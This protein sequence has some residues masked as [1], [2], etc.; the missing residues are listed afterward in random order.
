[1]MGGFYSVR[2]SH[3]LGKAAGCADWLVEAALE[4]TAN[5]GP[6]NLKGRKEI[7]NF[8]K[9]G[10]ERPKKWMRDEMIEQLGN[11]LLSRI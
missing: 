4:M 9:T 5:L 11:E 7:R 10:D 8:S 6:R 1:M 2:Q 3:C